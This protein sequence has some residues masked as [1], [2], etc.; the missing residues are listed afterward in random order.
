MQEPVCLDVEHEP[1]AI[2]RVSPTA[3]AY[4]APMVV[5]RGR[6]SAHRESEEPML[7]HRPLR[8]PVERFAVEGPINLRP[9][10]FPPPAKGRV[11]CLVEPHRIAVATAGRAVTG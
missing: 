11:R 2:R 6:R 1:A 8:T 5:C 4:I 3:T 10:E 7:T 9:G